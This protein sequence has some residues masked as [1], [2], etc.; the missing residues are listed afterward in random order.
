M[1]TESI[2]LAAAGVYILIRFGMGEALH[3]FTV[4]RGMFHSIPAAILFGELAFLLSSGDP[5]L[6]CYKAAA[7]AIGCLSHLLLDELCSLPLFGGQLGFKKSYGTALKLYG[8]HGWANVAAYAALVLVTFAVHREASA[9]ALPAAPPRKHVVNDW[10]ERI[11]SLAHTTPA[12]LPGRARDLFCVF[13]SCG[14]QARVGLLVAPANHCRLGRVS[15][16]VSS[17]SVTGPSLT[18]STCICCRNR[19]VAT[20]IFSRATRATNT[21]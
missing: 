12:G 21:S 15:S 10:G 16:P 5:A 7:V 8:R 13:S 6:R 1:S 3:R 20:G 19:P 11:K 17:N 18:N 9:T 14:G 4:H 2:V